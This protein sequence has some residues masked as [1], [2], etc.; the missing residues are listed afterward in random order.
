M[1]AFSLVCNFL[2]QPYVLQF[3]FI[4][5]LLAFAAV[6]VNAQGGATPIPIVSYVNEGVNH[7]G[8]YEWA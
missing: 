4:C 2:K 3:Q 6:S 5:L 8:S 7:D 1:L